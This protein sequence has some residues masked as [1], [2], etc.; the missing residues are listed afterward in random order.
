MAMNNEKAAIK[1]RINELRRQRQAVILAHNYQIG[2]VQDVADFLGDS[3]DLSQKARRIDARVIVFCGVHFMAETAAILSPEKVILLPELRAG[4]PMADMIDVES[5][6][7]LK[8]KHPRAK[9]VCYVNT[10]AE[11]KAESDVCCTSSNAAEIVSRFPADQE[12][13]FVPDR[14]LGANVQEQTGR[15]L[16][17]WPGYCHVHDELRPEDIEQKRAQF[18]GAPVIVHPECRPEVVQRADAALSTSGMVRF[19]ADTKAPT[20]VVGTEL[21]L[22]YRLEKENPTKRFVPL[23]EK[24]LCPNMKRT[25]LRKIAAALETMEPR[26]TVPEEIRLRAEQ[27]VLRMTDANL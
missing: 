7:D 17:L 11:V 12:I 19:A 20:V 6:V 4:C 5:L 26:I 10:T 22:C 13:I 18:P 23:S 2:E 3:L 16:I 21:G 25:T 15:K 8:A 14:N 27:A 9:V 1:A 24:S